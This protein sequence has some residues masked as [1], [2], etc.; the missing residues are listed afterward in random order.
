ME[1][2][3]IGSFYRISVSLIF[4]RVILGRE[5]LTNREFGGEN[6]P[7]LRTGLK[8]RKKGGGAS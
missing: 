6:E 5:R 3:K 7:Y 1:A 2:G 8:E 4:R